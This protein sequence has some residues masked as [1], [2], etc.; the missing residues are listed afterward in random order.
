MPFAGQPGRA[1]ISAAGLAHGLRSGMA[2][3]RVDAAT[4]DAL[5]AAVQ[6]AF[7]LHQG[8]FEQLHAVE[9]I[10]CAAAAWAL[11]EA[12][13]GGITQLAQQRLRVRPQRRQC[14]AQWQ[15][16]AGQ[17]QRQQRGSGAHRRRGQC[18][19]RPAP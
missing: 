15:A 17:G 10:R 5:V 16:P 14:I 7:I 2:S 8:L 11:S 12:I 6:L 1:R 19:R 13:V 4:A 9:C 3:V 18:W